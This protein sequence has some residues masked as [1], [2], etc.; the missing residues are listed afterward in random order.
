MSTPMLR[1][2]LTA[3]LFGSP[4]P[5][6]AHSSSS[7]AA[8]RRRGRPPLV[9]REQTLEL[10]RDAAREGRLFRVHLA[11]PAL[12]ARARRLWGSWAEAL[13]AAGVDHAAI[14]ENARRASLETRRT[15]RGN[16]AE[17]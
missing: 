8:P 10:I 9:T 1:R 4:A 16:G 2:A 15:R 11:Q 12:Y 3:A 5:R 7:A 13:R 14:V 17:T 6:G